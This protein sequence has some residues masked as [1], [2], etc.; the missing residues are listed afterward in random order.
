M[1]DQRLRRLENVVLMLYK[2]FFLLPGT[3]IAVTGKRLLWET[4][5]WCTSPYTLA[6]LYMKHEMYYD[7]TNLKCNIN[8]KTNDA[9]ILGDLQLFKCW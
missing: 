8:K 3:V 5:M 2:C 7:F 1:L 4:C 9:N 6:A